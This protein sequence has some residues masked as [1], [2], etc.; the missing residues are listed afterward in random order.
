V[1]AR[2]YEPDVRIDVSL[3]TAESREIYIG[4]HIV[5]QRGEPIGDRACRGGMEIIVITSDKPRATSM[6]FHY[7]RERRMISAFNPPGWK[8]QSSTAVTI[9]FLLSLS[10]F[11]YMRPVWSRCIPCFCDSSVVY[12]SKSVYWAK[13]TD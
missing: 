6:R 3:L 8:V 1:R 11:V 13:R 4:E 12:A 10:I 2:A 5:G 7:M 9:R